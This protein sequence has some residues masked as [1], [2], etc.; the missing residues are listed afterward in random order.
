MQS[1]IAATLLQYKVEYYGKIAVR[2]P[3]IIVLSFQV[4]GKHN[5]CFPPMDAFVTKYIHCQ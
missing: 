4:A 2:Q 5:L 3:A 1:T